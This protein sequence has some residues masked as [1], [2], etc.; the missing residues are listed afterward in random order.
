M[1]FLNPLESLLKKLPAPIRNRYFLVIAV[2]VFIMIFVDKHNIMTQLTLHNA[3]QQLETDK[4]YYNEKI[5][6]TKERR[7]D[8]DKNQEKYARENYFVKKAKEEVFVIEE[9]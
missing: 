4:S 7:I 2:F 8:F 3:V 5:Q 1:K 6:E 9:Y